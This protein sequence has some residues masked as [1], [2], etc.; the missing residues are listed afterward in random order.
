MKFG[1]YFK[2]NILDEW[3]YFYIDYK[4][5]KKTLKE[6]NSVVFYNLINLELLKLND[7]IKLINY[8]E[9]VDLK[10]VSNF[11]VLNYMALFKSI[12]KHDKKLSKNT[13][14]EFFKNISNSSFYRY[15]LSIPRKFNNIKLVIF[16][17]DGTLINHEKIF[18]KWLIKIVRSLTHII[19]DSDKLFNHLG[20]DPNK[21]K[22][23]F[24]S[25]VAKGT[26]DDIRN[27]IFEFI[28]DNNI[29]SNN[30]KE[31][32]QKYW[33]PLDFKKEDIIQCGNIL[34]VFKY[35]KSNNIKIAVCTS[36]DRIPTEKTFKL[37]NLNDYIDDVMCG[38]DPI[39][40]KPSP[41][42]IWKICSNLDIN[43]ENTLMIGD[44]ISDIDNEIIDSIDD[45]PSIIESIQ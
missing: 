15:Y 38:D 13:K 36:D 33:L 2:N 19:N 28:L 31:E 39:S 22:F 27:S 16:D 3:K 34:K 11:L 14:I 21:D 6:S 24:D 26:N 44:T 10:K 4:K 25:V 30:L 37:L 8:Y 41:E 23:E 12:K 20:Y 5:L 17:K 42:P 7:F 43:I 40:S 1:K 29:N 35:L 18:G 45:L 32:I 9:N